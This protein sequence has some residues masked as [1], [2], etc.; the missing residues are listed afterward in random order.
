MDV[1]IFQVFSCVALRHFETTTSK[2]MT[3]V[4]FDYDAY[5]SATMES[6]FTTTIMSNEK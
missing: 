4:V 3:G 6:V 2:V 5:F 1:V